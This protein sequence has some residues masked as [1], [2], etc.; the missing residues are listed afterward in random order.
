MT[1]VTNETTEKKARKPR[2]DKG[3]KKAKAARAAKPK[4]ETKSVVD[5]RYLAK[6]QTH[7]VKTASGKR[8]SVDVGDRLAAKLRGMDVAGVV[9]VLKDN[10]IEVPKNLKD[11]N[12][13][14]ARMVLGNSL[15]GF[16]RK[17]GKLNI[18]GVTIASL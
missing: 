2:K 11:R 8:K 15:R 3:V 6:Y 4:G 14:M 5:P 10:G 18:G 7:D 17:G 13:G 1:D 12:P 16:I 9:K